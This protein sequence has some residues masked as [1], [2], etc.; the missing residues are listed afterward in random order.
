MLAYSLKKCKY[1][2][3][4]TFHFMCEWGGPRRLKPPDSSLDRPLPLRPAPPACAH[5]TADGDSPTEDF[6][7]LEA[8]AKH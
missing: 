1:R 7:F 4:L 3:G 8:S 2:W 5:A 6:F